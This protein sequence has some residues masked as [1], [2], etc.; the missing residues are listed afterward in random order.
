MKRKKKGKDHRVRGSLA[1]RI[2]LIALVFLVIPLLALVGLLYIEDLRIKSDNNY[3]T[4]KLLMGQ[5]ADFV[6]KMIRHELDFVGG[7]AYLL[8]QIADFSS[9]L[10][11]LA[12]RE[13]VS[14]LFHLTEAPTGHFYSDMASSE[15]YLGKDYSELVTQ[16]K[17]GTVFVV[18]SGTD[19]FYLTQPEK[20]GAG[21]W[22]IA[23]TLPRVLD[24]FSIEH[25]VIRPASISLIANDGTIFSSTKTQFKKRRLSLP[26]RGEYQYKGIDYVTLVRPIPETNFSLMIAAPKEINFVD[27]PYFILKVGIALSF[28]VV[29]GGGGALLLTKKF[30]RPLKKLIGVMEQVGKGD[31]SCRFAVQKMG[32]EINTIGKIFNE[33]VDSLNANMEAVQ[34]E[35]V[36]RETY[37]KELRIGEEVQRSILPKKV[38]EFPGL[39]M[40]ARFIAAKEVGGDFYDFLVKDRLMLSIGDTAGKGISACLYSLSVRSMLRSYGQ[41]YRELDLILKETNDLFCRDTG[42]TG[43]FVTAFVAF[44]DPETKIF[45]YSNCGHF[46]PLRLKNDGTVERLTTNGTALG[47]F[48]FD[49]VSTARIT[50]ESGDRLVLF[51]DGIV[52]AHNRKMELFG[53][54]R[55]IASLQ[56]KKGWETREIVDRVI[57]EVTLFAE[58]T[59]QFDDLSLV[60]V[61]I[62]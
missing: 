62:L 45:H 46:P 32:F 54:D 53:E 58:G 13:K 20:N 12:K 49:A 50:L 16:A 44:F 59:A 11:E 43:V 4:L 42:D 56:R 34:K 21:A 23:F 33:T 40:A 37:E 19:L 7:I 39:E 41:I 47:V 28:I 52:E 1:S 30:S 8:P 29:I 36:E 22:V 5:K 15:T 18:D 25:P 55:F 51:T 31:L 2:L 27:I 61:K 14:A 9:T 57:E 38:P 3:F 48:P 10:Q 35:R 17:K 26:V 6:R 24:N 60:V